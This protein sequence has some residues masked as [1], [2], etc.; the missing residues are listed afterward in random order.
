[1]E[2]T[3]SITKQTERHITDAKSVPFGKIPTEHMFMAEYKEGGWQNAR[4]VPFQDLTLSP[5]SLCLHYGQTVFE[6]MK[7]F[8]MEDGK[9]NIFRIDKH[10]DRFCKSLQRMCMLI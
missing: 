9:I 6:G 5:L 2:H 3:I 1:M 4:V 7:A 10:Y 8:V